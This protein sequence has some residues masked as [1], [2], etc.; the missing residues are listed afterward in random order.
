MRITNKDLK[1]LVDQLNELKGISTAPGYLTGAFHLEDNYGGS[2]LILI[3][4]E[5]GSRTGISD[6]I[7]NKEMYAFLKGMLTG[8][9]YF[10][11]NK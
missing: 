9:E 10:A 5:S 7:S 3:T 6:T 2:R 4:S 1:S 11:K 8:I